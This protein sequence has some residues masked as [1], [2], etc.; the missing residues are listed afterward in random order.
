MRDD[1][2]GFI[3]IAVPFVLYVCH[4]FILLTGGY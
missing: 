4:G 3:L 2:T 1:I